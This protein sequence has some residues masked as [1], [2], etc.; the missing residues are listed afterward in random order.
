MR[1]DWTLTPDDDI[2]ESA[3]DGAVSMLVENG[4]VTSVEPQDTLLVADHAL[5]SLFR[6]VPV[7]ALQLVTGHAQL[8]PLTD[9]QDAV[10]PVND[11]RMGMGEDGTDS[12]QP[13]VHRVKGVGIEAGRRGF[14]Q[15]YQF[16]VT[17]SAQSRSLRRSHVGFGNS[18]GRKVGNGSK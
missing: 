6:V 4:L 5:F 3:G 7:T 10:V 12:G 1:V 13:T 18:V 11:L 16:E 8:A 15:A 14:S 2:L 9:G 17:Q